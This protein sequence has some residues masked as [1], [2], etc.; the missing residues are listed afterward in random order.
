VLGDSEAVFWA[1]KISSG[2]LFV[3][4]P[5]EFNNLGPEL[6]TE[7][8]DGWDTG[9]GGVR[10]HTECTA[11]RR[12]SQRDACEQRSRNQW[13]P[14]P[15]YTPLYLGS[16][17]QCARRQ[18][19]PLGTRPCREAAAA[20]GPTQSHTS[21]SEV[22]T[23]ARRLC[24][25]TATAVM[26]ASAADYLRVGGKTRK[27][28]RQ[29]AVPSAGLSAHTRMLAT[30]AA[31]PSRPNVTRGASAAPGST[32]C[33]TCDDT[34]WSERRGR[35]LDVEG[36]AEQVHDSGAVG[37]CGAALRSGAR[38]HHALAQQRPA[39]QLLFSNEGKPAP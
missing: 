14:P 13:P 9:T 11:R 39:P 33:T 17:R 38:R 16:L 20:G 27:R 5:P 8:E 21:P 35:L 19:P 12:G 7:A 32:G 36:R 26:A 25:A 31:S 2:S 15:R 23:A 3:S 6:F 10:T 34:A 30:G 4:R 18:Y 37:E 28:S 22:P 29:S 24:E 1:I